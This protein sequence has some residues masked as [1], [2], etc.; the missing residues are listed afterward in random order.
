MFEQIDYFID[1]YQNNTK[2][3][4]AWIILF[5]SVVFALD[6][7]LVQQQAAVRAAC[8]VI[9]DRYRTPID[10]LENLGHCQTFADACDSSLREQLT[11]GYPEYGNTSDC[12]C[13]GRAISFQR[14]VNKKA[15][16]VKKDNLLLQETY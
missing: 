4:K 5:I 3:M 12:G 16:V 13:N 9:T 1:Q 11:C 8:S 10:E 2:T 6:P 14:M 7:A 15:N